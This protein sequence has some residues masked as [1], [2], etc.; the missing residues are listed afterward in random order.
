[1]HGLLER[2]NVAKADG[3]GNSRRPISERTQIVLRGG[4]VLADA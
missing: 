4:T 2:V 1:M 3:R